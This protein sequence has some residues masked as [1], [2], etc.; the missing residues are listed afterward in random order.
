MADMRIHSVSLKQFFLFL[1]VSLFWACQT[2]HTVAPDHIRIRLAGE[3]ST[4]HP[5]LA[6]DA[7]AS[8][9]SNYVFDSLVD[10]D[11]DTTEYRPKIALKWDIAPDHKTYTFYLR[12]DV[13]WHDGKPLTADDVVFTLNYIKDPK[14]KAPQLKVYYKDIK[15]IR[16]IDD[17]TVQFVYNEVYFK[18]FLLCGGMTILP[19]HILEKESDS[20]HS[21]FSRAPVG[22]GPYRFVA[23]ETGKRIRL[24]R[25]EEYWG[26][27]PAIRRLDFNIIQDASVGLQILKKG[28]VDYYDLRTIQWVKQTSSKKFDSL[29][30]KITYPGQMYSYIGWNLKSPIFSD[31]RVRQAMTMSINRDLIRDKYL[32]GLAQNMTG[33]FF[34]LGKQNDAAIQPLPYDLAKAKALLAQAG[35]R[36]SNGDGILDRDGKKFSFEFL[37]SA[38]STFAERL[39]TFMKEDLQKMGI[40]MRIVR[41]EFAA[42]LDRI[43]KREFDAI[44]LAWQSPVESDPYQLWHSSQV[45][46]QGSSNYI[47]F[48]NRQADWLMER[49][50]REFDEDRRNEFYH[51]FHKILHDEQPYT[52]LFSS[53]TLAAV[54]RRFDN[55]IIHKLGLDLMEWKSAKPIEN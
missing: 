13:R 4:L 38:G 14:T 48:A 17:Y 40:E 52:F 55:V 21:T 16:K 31:K 19:K 24:V 50:R 45:K 12:K 35:W 22:S 8:E 41:L 43:G 42:F 15:K 36:D 44:T 9:I 46:V 26:N 25:N 37:Y 28:L 39:A 23:W 32:F 10:L 11:P 20:D 5:I 51:R 1:S 7:Y 6:S 33:P 3:P 54:S 49:A 47:S 29:F 30:R 53:P 2:H 34:P 27:K 18:G